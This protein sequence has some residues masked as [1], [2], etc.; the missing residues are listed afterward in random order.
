MAVLLALRAAVLLPGA[1]DFLGVGLLVTFLLLVFLL[2]VE[3]EPAL[4]F[5]ALLGSLVTFVL[6]LAAVAVL[7]AVLAV[8]A[9]T[10]LFVFTA[11]VGELAVFFTAALRAVLDTVLAD[12]ELFWV[13]VAVF[14]AL[15]AVVLVLLARVVVFLG[16]AL[17]LGSTAEALVRGLTALLA[18]FLTVLFLAIAMVTL[19]KISPCCITLVLAAPA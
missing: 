16:L 18:V 4:L 13:V 15:A 6:R 10:G 19:L 11:L 9:L 8:L 3:V 14:F 1:G 2:G 12:F 7:L 5:L 17:V